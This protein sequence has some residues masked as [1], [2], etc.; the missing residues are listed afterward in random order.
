M[1]DQNN[2]NENIEL[3]DVY[4]ARLASEKKQKILQERNYLLRQSK[5]V[6]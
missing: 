5:M 1:S 3:K 6:Y 2:N 4:K